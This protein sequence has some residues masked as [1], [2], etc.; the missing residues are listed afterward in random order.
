MAPWRR[1]VAVSVFMAVVASAIAPAAAGGEGAKRAVPDYD[2]RGAAP[3][4]VGDVLLWIPRVAM[5][6]LYLV[7]EFVVRRPL[8][9]LVTEAERAELP[10]LLGRIFTFNDGKA[11]IV[12]TFMFDFGVAAGAM[13]SGGLYIFWDD[14]LYDGHDLRL[15]AAFGGADWVTLDFSSRFGL[16][17]AG[18]LALGVAWDR[19]KDWIFAGVGPGFGDDAVARYGED[20]VTG[21]LDWERP[22]GARGWIAIGAHVASFDFFEGRC[23]DDP[24][25]ATRVAEGRYPSPDGFDASYTVFEPV[26]RLALDTRASRPGDESGVRAEAF[27]GTAVGLSGPSDGWVRYGADVG[28]YLDVY[29]NRTLGL[30]ARAELV[31]PL[32]DRPVPFS[33]LSLLGGDA[34][35]RAFSAGRLRGESALVAVLDYRWPIWVFLDG[36]LFVELGN[37]FGADF[38]GLDV[39]A[40]RLSFGLGVRPASQ[41]DHPFEL[42]VAAG[43]DAFGDG[44]AVTSLRVVFGTS[45]GF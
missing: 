39:D 36:H 22:L 41:E 28:A 21:S 25:V 11:G 6:P 27:V 34:P 44:G 4:T 37:A 1:L 3:T 18:R 23:C 5:S 16:G 43:T 2:G 24:T 17:E 29:N 12:P 15:R 45:S 33:E 40:L 13:S 14:A 32:D 9:F 10:A 35:M 19:R 7:T 26:A 31:S 38:A 30:R 20:R 42:L 8:G